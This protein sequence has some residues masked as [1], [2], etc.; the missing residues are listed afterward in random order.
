MAMW[1]KLQNSKIGIWL[2]KY[3]LMEKGYYIDLAIFDWFIIWILQ[4]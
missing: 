2:K 1:Y 3:S 4:S